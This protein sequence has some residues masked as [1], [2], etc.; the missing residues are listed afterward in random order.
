MRLMVDLGNEDDIV[1][2]FIFKEA[3]TPRGVQWGQGFIVRTEDVI[4]QTKNGKQALNKR[5]R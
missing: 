3:K 2:L 4:A 5:G 1:S